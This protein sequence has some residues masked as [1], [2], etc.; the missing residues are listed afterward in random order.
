[1]AKK[2][3]KSDAEWRAQLTPEQYEVVRQ[4]GTER[5]FTGKFWDHHERGRLHLRRVRRAAVRLRR[6]VRVRLRLAELLRA[7]RRE[8]RRDR[9][10]RQPLHAPHRGALRVVRRAPRPRLRRRP[11]PDR[12]ALLHQLREPGLREEGLIPPPSLASRDDRAAA[13]A[14]AKGSARAFPV[15]SGHARAAAPHTSSTLLT[16]LAVPP[17]FERAAT[18][19]AGALSP[20]RGEGGVMGDESTALDGRG[21]AP[22]AA[23]HRLRRAGEGRR[24]DPRASGE[25]RGAAADRLLDFKPAAFQPAGQGS[26]AA[27]EQLAQVHDRG[28]EPA[29]G[30]A[31][32]VL[33]RPL[34]D[35]GEQGR[36]R[37]ADRGAEPPAA[38]E[39]Q[40]QL[41]HAAAA[42]STAT[43]RCSSSSTPSATASARRTRTTARELCELFALGVKDANGNDNYLQEDVVQIAR[44]FTGWR[45]EKDKP[46]LQRARPRLRGGLPRARAEGDLHAGRRLRRRAGARS[47]APARGAHGDRR[48]GRHPARA[49]RQRRPRHGRA[50]HRAPPARVLRARRVRAE[51]AGDDRGGRRGG[52]R[53]GLRRAAG[54]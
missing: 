11:A 45:I 21:R 51:H 10:R 16:Q 38:Q 18:P 23:P 47:R 35:R 44:A 40:G 41:P 15:P 28:E 54:T 20:G 32:P 46:L 2:V 43:R 5:A 26:A 33:A 13:P 25:T 53:I 48:R 8:Q 6:Q 30:E 19:L 34:R 1:M 17:S 36:Q 27:P 39:L 50:P 29:A 7:A 24:A 52:R 31:G 37:Q 22:S 3:E 49:P 42:R 4:K 9:G 12:P 14:S